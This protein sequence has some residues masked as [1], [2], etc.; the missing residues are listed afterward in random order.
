MSLRGHGM[1]SPSSVTPSLACMWGRH[2]D[3]DGFSG[4]SH[5]AG[6]PCGCHEEAAS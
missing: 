6:C 1:F 2:R 4:P 5:L 3:C